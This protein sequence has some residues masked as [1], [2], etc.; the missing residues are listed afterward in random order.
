MDIR[1]S[2]LEMIR[3]YPGG[4]DAMAAALG[5][6]RMALENRI[7]ER[8]GQSLLVET[9]MMMQHM[10]GTSHYAEAVAQQSGGVFVML[11]KVGD[12]GNEELLNEFTLL[13][14]DLG[15]LST[16]FR[17]AVVDNEI[18]SKERDRL[19]ETARKIHQTVQQLLALMFMVYCK[20][21]AE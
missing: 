14:E 8:K 6:T 16:E 17:K 15:K 20:P 7:Y 11:P 19:D 18:D 3:A 2:Y 10:S 9:A 1:K 4:W 13:Y 21:E 5:M 12:I